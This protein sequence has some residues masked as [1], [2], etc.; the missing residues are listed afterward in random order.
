MNIRMRSVVVAGLGLA[1]LLYTANPSAAQGTL[2]RPVRQAAAAELDLPFARCTV[3]D[4]GAQASLDGLIRVP[5]VLPT[6]PATLELFPHSVRAEG[7][8]VM[9]RTAEGLIAAALPAPKT[10]RGRLVEDHAVQVVASVIDG[11]VTANIYP[12]GDTDPWCIQPR[13][14]FDGHENAPGTSHVVYRASDAI[15]PP[16]MCGNDERLCL[17]G[18]A[19]HGTPPAPRG[20]GSACQRIAEILF[21]TDYEFFQVYGTVAATIAGVEAYLNQVDFIY[22][23]DLGTS[24][25]TVQ[26][27]VTS[28]APAVD[29]PYL[30]G[31]D[32]Y[33]V[34]YG[35]RDYWATQALPQRDNVHLLIA[36]NTGGIAGLAYVGATCAGGGYN[37]G[38]SRRYTSDFNSLVVVIAHEL[39]HNMG[40][41]HDNQ[42]GACNDSPF[43]H[44]MS[45]SVNTS[46][47]SFSPCT[48]VNINN[49]LW[50]PGGDCLQRLMPGVPFGRPDAGAG[51]RGLTTFVDVL[52]NDL[53][54]ET[55]SLQLVSGTSAGGAPVSISPGTGWAG[56]DRVAYAAAVGTPSTDTFQYRAVNNSG[57][58][59]PITVTMTNV[60]ARVPENPAS[61]ESG[62]DVRYYALPG[63]TG[64]LPNFDAL[65]AYATSTAATIN[66]PSS[67]GVFSDSGRAD[68]VGAVYVG[69][70]DAP[71]TGL[72]TLYI[73]SD[74]GSRIK[75]G[76]TTVVTN[77]F[78]HGMVEQGGQ[79][80]L[81]AGKHALRVE[82]F[83]AGGGAGLIMR[84]AGPG[85]AKQVVGADRL[86]SDAPCPTDLDNSGATDVPD[87]F[88]FL[89]L[90]FANDAAADW[91]G[92]GGV[93]VPDI[94]AFLSDWFANGG[95]C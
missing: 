25:T 79:I 85:I 3:Q 40:T 84:W 15:R 31:V 88:A 32:P 46:L 91:D 9:E 42:G 50:G 48:T 33:A 58:S 17:A 26:L 90:W 28:S 55:M 75:I 18:C 30:V 23:R 45:P 66:V 83:E 5:V 14:Q 24:I 41:G 62:L 72:Y 57:A 80:A 71:T 60:S 8:Q 69:Y 52:P 93:A 4:L 94:F 10:Y 67:N 34:L 53:S 27:I 92:A 16:M 86:Y 89:A 68:D 2:R 81:G 35:F 13:D 77:D 6:G 36:R 19:D 43:G 64:A 87:I 39:G 22:E 11:Q 21:E 1:A 59:A 12:P 29:H 7:Y 70:L 51:V 78:L 63:G 56:S 74:D 61:T 37:S 38:L 47:M 73:E 49:Y 54:C 95:P 65:T 20:P 82:F 44:I 76:T